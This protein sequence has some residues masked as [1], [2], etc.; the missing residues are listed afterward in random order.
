[1]CIIAVVPP[2]KKLTNE[3]IENCS[4]A[5]P[6]GFGLTYV[7]EGVFVTQK[8]LK[9]LD[10]EKAL[11]KRAF[12]NRGNSDIILH[13]RIAT[14]GGINKANCH[15][16]PIGTDLMGAHNGM[17]PVLLDNAKTKQGRSDTRIFF[18]EYLELLPKNWLYNCYMVD[19][20][21]DYINGSKIAVLDLTGQ[22]HILRKGDAEEKG[23]IW[24]SNTAFKG[25]RYKS[26]ANPKSKNYDSNNSAYGWDWNETSKSTPLDDLCDYCDGPLGNDLVG[27]VHGICAQCAL[28]ANQC[29]GCGAYGAYKEGLCGPC[30][31][32]WEGC[33]DGDKKD[34]KK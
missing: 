23:G 33:R 9:G 28:D 12:K 16:F 30:I 14:H 2:N 5:N 13:W 10:A 6:D 26:Y 17:L 25:Y 21:E 20:I 15:P 8:T 11:I 31:S 34:G 1:M 19:L 4:I 18:Q 32:A 3:Q 24:F 29:A 22:S 27:Y 7:T